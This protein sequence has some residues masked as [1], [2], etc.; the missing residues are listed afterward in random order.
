MTTMTD[1]PRRKRTPRDPRLVELSDE[2]LT[3]RVDRHFLPALPDEAFRW[4]FRD[5]RNRIV[6]DVLETRRKCQRCGSVEIR[7]VDEGDGSLWRPTRYEYV[8]GYQVVNPEGMTG[9]TPRAASRLEHTRRY[10]ERTD[11]KRVDRAL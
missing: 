10:L 3:C 9:P 2:F 11:V 5:S 8:R 6:A 1:S 4:R 7:M